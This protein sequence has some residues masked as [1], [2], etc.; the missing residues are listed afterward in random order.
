MKTQ[1]HLSSPYRLSSIT[2]WKR[3]PSSHSQAVLLSLQQRYDET[4]ALI[5]SILEENRKVESSIQ[6]RCYL[7]LVEAI[8]SI[9]RIR[10]E[11]KEVP[12]SSGL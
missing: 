1:N 4:V 9:Y 10:G 7:L 3:A 12:S 8:F 2:W 5:S 11:T 6:L